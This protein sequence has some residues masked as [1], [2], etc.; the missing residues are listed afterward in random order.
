MRRRPRSSWISHPCGKE[1]T[2]R[3]ETH[4]GATVDNDSAVWV[5]PGVELE[6]DAGQARIA[7]LKLVSPQPLTS[8]VSTT[9]SAQTTDLGNHR[10]EIAAPAA[11]TLY[12]IHSSV[13]TAQL[14]LSLKEEPFDSSLLFENGTE[15]SPQGPFGGIPG[16]GAVLGVRN[17]VSTPTRRNADRPMSITS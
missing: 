8:V 14:P 10:Y 15:S 17:K 7:S 3:L 16:T 5:K 2:I 12:L 11:G 1:I 4:P 13:G 6:S 9:G